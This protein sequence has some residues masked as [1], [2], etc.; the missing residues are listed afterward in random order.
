MFIKE[1]DD[2]LRLS[3][4]SHRTRLKRYT[5]YSCW[6]VAGLALCNASDTR[7]FIKGFW[8]SEMFSAKTEFIT[9][10][11][12]KKRVALKVVR[13]KVVHTKPGRITN[14]CT[15]FVS[16]QLTRPPSASG[17]YTRR[18]DKKL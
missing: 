1:V 14:A 15:K 4:L 7:N 5:V 16:L 13:S 10:S 9:F 12:P 2:K 6:Q 18:C 17:L 3:L 8:L 11:S